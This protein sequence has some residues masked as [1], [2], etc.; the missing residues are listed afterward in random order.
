MNDERFHLPVRIGD[1][2]LKNPFVVASG[3]TTKRIEQLELA[4]RCGW[5]AASLKHTFN[6][7]PYINYQPRYRWLKKEKL[8]TFTAEYRLDMESGLRLVEAARKTGKP[9]FVAAGSDA[10]AS[11]PAFSRFSRVADS[12]AGRLLLY[13]EKRGI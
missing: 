13:N 11:V 8:H 2:E 3:P 12:V 9:I 5:A 10:A 1:V 7:A 6:P 4:E